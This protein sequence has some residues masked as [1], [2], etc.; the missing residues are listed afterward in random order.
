MTRA[1]DGVRDGAKGAMSPAGA[2]VSQEER[3]TGMGDGRAEGAASGACDDAVPAGVPAPQEAAIGAHDVRVELDAREILRGVDLAAAKGELV[4]LIGPNGSG[5]STLLKCIYRVL[6]PSGGAVY[7]DGRPLSEY[8]VRQSA[9]ALAVMAQHTAYNFEFTVRD[10]VLLGRAPRKRALERDTATDYAIVDEALRTV[11]LSELAARAFSTL[12]GGEQQRVILARALA[13]QTPLLILDEPTNH[14]DVRYQ[15]ELMDIVRGLGKTVLCAVH[16]LNIAAM[17]CD[18]LYALRQG[19]VVASGTPE[20]VITPEVIR[21]VY[22]VE[23]RVIED[24]D[25][26]RHVLYRPGGYAPRG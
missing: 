16:D 23:A 17:Y 7:L 2:P 8:S 11:G 1:Q 26:T 21:A 4:G 6:A 15:L 10:I 5:K 14:L 12:S 24:E 18:R 3:R 25:G 19:R 13:Q 9:Q 22:D 20:Q